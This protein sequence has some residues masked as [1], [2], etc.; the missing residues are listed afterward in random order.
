MLG[1]YKNEEAT[2]NTIDADGWYHT[3]DLGTMDA[4]GNIFIKGRSKNMLLGSNGQNIYPEEIED[5]LNSMTLVTESLVVQRGD[6]L[7]ALIY[8]DYDE[9]SAMGLSADDLKNVMEQNRQELNNILPVYSKIAEV[10]IQEEEFEKTPKKS[11]KRY[12]YK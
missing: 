8:P 12:L 4:E 2:R 11:I 3:G 6:K 5:K 7:A 9:A 10:V 1:Y